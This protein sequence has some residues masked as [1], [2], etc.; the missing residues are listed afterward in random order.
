MVYWCGVCS[1]VQLY[2]TVTVCTGTFST[3][4]NNEGITVKLKTGEVGFEREIANAR[5]AFQSW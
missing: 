2:L 1:D 3:L 5:C 4:K